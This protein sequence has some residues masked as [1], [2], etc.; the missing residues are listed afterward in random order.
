MKNITLLF[1]LILLPVVGIYG[2]IPQAP[3]ALP[4]PTASGLGLY[5]EIPVS[6]F[7]GTPSIQVP[8]YELNV[9]KY[10]LPLSL[11]YH[12]SGLRPDQHPGW[13]GMGW[14]LSA[15]AVITRVVHDLVDEYNR[16]SSDYTVR[17]GYYFSHSI[18][19]KT[20]WNEIGRAHV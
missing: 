18:P 15:N 2:Q 3:Q 11:S 12:A 1:I 10:R 17:A 7:T 8:L 16:P 14:S 13:L 20:N 19:D 9:G 4:S 5:G 6:H